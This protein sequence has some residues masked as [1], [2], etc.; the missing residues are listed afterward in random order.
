MYNTPNA[1]SRRQTEYGALKYKYTLTNHRYPF[2]FFK[3]CWYVCDMF[4]LKK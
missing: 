1:P 2:A 4:N 3:Y